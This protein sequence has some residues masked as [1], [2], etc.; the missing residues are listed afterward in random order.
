MPDQRLRYLE[1]APAGVAA[2]SSVEHYLNTATALPAVL[3]ELVRLRCSQLN[4]CEY[5]IGLHTHEL[6]THN[7]PQSRIDAVPAWRGSDAFT[8][9]EASALRWAEAITTIQQGHASD[10]EFAA[11]R[12]HFNDRDLVDL[13]LAIASINAF[14]RMAIAFRP[15]WHGDAPRP[16]DS[17]DS[18]ANPATG[19]DDPSAIGDDGGKVSVDE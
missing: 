11:V 5:C 9:T 1:I 19:S 7:E 18:Q 16:D 8:A 13:T 6:G 14:N 2:Q 4:G 12:E 15:Q 17:K 3:L 10:A